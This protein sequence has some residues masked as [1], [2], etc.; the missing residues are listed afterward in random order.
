[1]VKMLFMDVDGTLTDGTIYIGKSGEEMKGFSV[2]DGYAIH[3]LLPKYNIIPVIIT[4]R[5]SIFVQS[6]AKEL[7]I[8]ELYQGVSDKI[9]TMKA[10]ASKYGC[11]LNEV[12]YIGDDIPDLDCL[13]IAGV[14]G[15]PSDAAD[16]VKQVCDYICSNGGG[17]GAVR[18][19]IEW[20][21]ERGE[22]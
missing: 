1:M 19:F 15:C 14:S 5:R 10:A 18:E 21:I 8:K 12:A 6:R 20:L 11:E 17:K 13:I 4:A 7:G 22:Q 2:Q 3:E 9:D 16:R